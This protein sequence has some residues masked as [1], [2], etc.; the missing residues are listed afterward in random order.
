LQLEDEDGVDNCCRHQVVI[1]RFPTPDTATAT[2]RGDPSTM[3]NT[4]SAHS[5]STAEVRNVH[6]MPSGLVITRF[7]AP[8]VATA[9]KSGDPLG[10]PNVTDYQL[11]FAADE[12]RLQIIPLKLVITRFP[13]PD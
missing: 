9:T 2:K 12:Q 6:A 1:T 4:T 13:T 11:L 3:P 5:L 8:L 10:R 7:P